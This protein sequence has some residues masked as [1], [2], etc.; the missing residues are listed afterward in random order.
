LSF[1]ER[2]TSRGEAA[3][4]PAVRGCLRGGLRAD[5]EERDRKALNLPRASAKPLPETGHRDGLSWDEYRDLYY[6][7]SRRHTLEAIV[8]YGDYK[9]S[10]KDDKRSS[11]L[12]GNGAH[13]S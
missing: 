5:L 7:N 3:Y 1:I 4:R 11:K 9:R 12:A 8:A 2:S 6:P 13:V 10:S